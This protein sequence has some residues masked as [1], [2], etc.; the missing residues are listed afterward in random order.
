[1]YYYLLAIST[2]FPTFAVG[3]A[4]AGTLHYGN[5]LL[6]YC[7]WLFETTTIEL[8]VE[9]NAEVDATGRYI[10]PVGVPTANHAVMHTFMGHTYLPRAWVSLCLF[11]TKAVVG[12]E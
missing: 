1:M 12:L 10:L 7:F 4:D 6:T 2:F 9:N 5:A 3:S 8:V 11:T